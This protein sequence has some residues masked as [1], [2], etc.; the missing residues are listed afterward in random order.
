MA[1]LDDYRSYIEEIIN[2]RAEIGY[3]NYE[4][5]Q[6]IPVIDRE[7]DNYLLMVYG[8]EG[9]KRN[10][11]ALIHVGIRNGKFWIYYDGLE[12]GVATYLL[13]K[14][15]P[16]EDIVL[17]FYSPEKRKLTEFAIA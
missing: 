10:H 9:I 16:K 8:W 11:Y 1:K 6:M 3:K 7:R 17:A 2:W 4:D 12:D 5:L 13:E 14:G 15:V